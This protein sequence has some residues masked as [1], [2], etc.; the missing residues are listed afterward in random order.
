MYPLGDKSA[1]PV[2]QRPD[3]DAALDREQQ[4]ADEGS[5]YDF[6]HLCKGRSKGGAFAEEGANRGLGFLHLLDSTAHRMISA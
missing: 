1:H 5:L 6:A 3:W 2:Q 4:A